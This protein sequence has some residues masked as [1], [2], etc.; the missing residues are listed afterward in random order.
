MLTTND[1]VMLIF[2][3]RGH[4]LASPAFE[5]FAQ[6]TVTDEGRRAPAPRFGDPR[7][8][9]LA[10][11]LPNLLFAASGITN[12]SLR[13]QMTALLGTAYSMNQASYD[14]ARLRL[15]GLIHRVPGHNRYTLTPDGQQFAIFYTKVH[16]RGPPTAPQRPRPAQRPTRPPRRPAHHRPR[17]RPTP[18]PGAGPSRTLTHRQTRDSY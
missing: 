8:Q 2:S 10:G 3:G 18:Q 11:T 5:R 14:L 7:V 4:I 9:A 15:N 13:A 6:P 12:K 16:D 1:A 17:H